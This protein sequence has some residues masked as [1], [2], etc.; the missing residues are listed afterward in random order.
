MGA[1][2]TKSFAR[3]RIVRYG[4]RNDILSRGQKPRQGGGRTAPSPPPWFKGLKRL[5]SSPA[6]LQ[7]PMH[8]FC[9]I[10]KQYKIYANHCFLT[11]QRRLSIYGYLRLTLGGRLLIYELSVHTVQEFYIIQTDKPV[12]TG[13]YQL[14]NQQMKNKKIRKF[15][16]LIIAAQ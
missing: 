2:A 12:R 1:S 3:S 7:H 5:P 13:R 15:C 14:R 9:L 11:L 10:S 8:L 4:L 16:T 6:T